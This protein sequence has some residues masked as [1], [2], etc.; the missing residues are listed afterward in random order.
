LFLTVEGIDFGERIAVLTKVVSARL[1]GGSKFERFQPVTKHTRAILPLHAELTY[2]ATVAKILKRCFRNAGSEKVHFPENTGKSLSAGI[3]AM[4]ETVCAND[5]DVLSL[6]RGS[7]PRGE[8][9]IEIGIEYLE[10]QAL[11]ERKLVHGYVADQWERQKFM[12]PLPS[13]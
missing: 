10:A 5:T 8:A 2:P 13:A 7:R 6:Y 9:E 3:Y 4:V 11:V 1:E 12:A